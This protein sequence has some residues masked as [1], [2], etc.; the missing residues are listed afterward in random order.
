MVGAK[1]GL[2]ESIFMY[3]KQLEIAGFESLWNV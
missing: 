3:Q 2:P 1:L